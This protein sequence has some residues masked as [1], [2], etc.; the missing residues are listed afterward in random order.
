MISLDLLDSFSGGVIYYGL[1]GSLGMQDFG[2]C[3]IP[4]PLLMGW[5]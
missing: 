2:V 3:F 1:R 4:G 5:E